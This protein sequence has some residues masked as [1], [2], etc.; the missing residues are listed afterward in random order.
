ME[1]TIKTLAGNKYTVKLN[2]GDI[3]FHIKRKV[4]QLTNTDEN[5]V[6][7]IYSGTILK[8]AQ[9]IS[10]YNIKNGDFL[11]MLIKK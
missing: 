7:L 11:V 9:P 8:D 4:A 1:V 5:Q 2:D 10:S 3:V 6:K